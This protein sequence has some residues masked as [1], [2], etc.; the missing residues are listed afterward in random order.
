MTDVRFCLNVPAD[1]VAL[2]VVD[3]VGLCNNM[4]ALAAEA[5]TSTTSTR[6]PVPTTLTAAA[7]FKGSNG[8]GGGVVCMSSWNLDEDV[9][10]DFVDFER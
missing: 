2:V 6:G 8:L 9:G 1:I 3:I 4:L 5:A 7:G 10:A